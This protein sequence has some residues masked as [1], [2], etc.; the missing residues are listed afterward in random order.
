MPNN[1]IL[2]LILTDYVP[3]LTSSSVLVKQCFFS[4]EFAFQ[5]QL[6]VLWNYNFVGLNV[7]GCQYLQLYI[8]M[9]LKF[10]NTKLIILS[11]PFTQQVM[12]PQ[13]GNIFTIREH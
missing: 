6:P 4:K 1:L 12:S 9:N 7:Y 13:T 11:A 2:E 8:P 3:I 10:L 5:K